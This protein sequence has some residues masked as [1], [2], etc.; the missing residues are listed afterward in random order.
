M[1]TLINNETQFYVYNTSV[2]IILALLMS[3][4]VVL[5][6]WRAKRVSRRISSD[7]TIAMADL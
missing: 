6:I 1:D 4:V 2:L 5:T 3:L 7:A